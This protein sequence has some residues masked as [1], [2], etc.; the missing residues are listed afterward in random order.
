[1]G[2]AGGLEDGRHHTGSSTVVASADYAVVYSVDS[3]GGTLAAFEID[4]QDV[5]NVDLGADPV[6][7]ARAGDEL[8]VTLRGQR[9]IAVVRDQDGELVVTDRIATGAEPYGIV[10]SEDG[11]RIYFTSS[12]SGLVHEL[13]A[14]TH[15]ELRRWSVPD[16]PRWLAL[17]PSGESL[18]VG[19]AYR[20]T[21]TWIDLAEDNV[22]SVD[23]P[24]LTGNALDDFRVIDLVPRVT[25]DL[26]VT[27]NGKALIV[28]TL[29]VDNES[30]AASGNGAVTVQYYAGSN[31]STRFNPVA[32]V[33]PLGDG[34]TPV[35]SETEAIDLATIDGVDVVNSYVTSIQLSP[36]GEDVYA[37]MES[38]SM[39]VAFRLSRTGATGGP[40]GLSSAADRGMRIISGGSTATT[41]AVLPT[42][43]DAGPT[44]LVFLSDTEAWVHSFLGRT[45]SRLDADY[46]HRMLQPSDADVVYDESARSTR[47]STVVGTVALTGQEITGRALFFSSTN[48]R[49]SGPGA[50]VSCSTC[51][52]DG[53]NDGLSWPLENGPRQTPSLAGDVSATVPM[54]WTD[55]VATVAEEAMITST[56]RMGGSGVSIDDADAIA[57]FI[58]S[59]PEVDSVLKGSSDPAVERGEAIFNSAD[60][61]C[62]ECHTGAMLTDNRSYSMFDLAAVDTRSLVGVSA[63][64]PYLH[65]GRV[66]TLRELLEMVSDGEMGDTSDL[67]GADLDDLEAYLR[68]L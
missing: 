13:D 9:E 7:V 47:D 43:V 3:E 16:Q 21:L 65:D 57:A 26:A 62:S 25:G 63:T 50:G 49:M 24:T 10:A 68:S 17:H 61:A 53:R 5:R 64:A 35:T 19:S 34:G 67:S 59:T 39:V 36:N 41:R 52:F 27:P 12:L 32:V 45:V 20:G 28:P 42:R 14:S 4:S 58:D 11:E 51:H 38:S 29:Y 56:T 48:R 23:L 1:M 40:Q 31:G 55:Q 22:A 6:R 46:T 66:A 2:C 37:T 54:T 30:G 44:G 18:Y 15:E 8:L 33:I 60:A